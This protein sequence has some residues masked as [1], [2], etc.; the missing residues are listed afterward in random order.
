MIS[1][2]MTALR[3][4]LFFGGKLKLEERDDDMQYPTGELPLNSTAYQIYSF[5]MEPWTVS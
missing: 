2:D 4:K 3:K 5:S 1:N